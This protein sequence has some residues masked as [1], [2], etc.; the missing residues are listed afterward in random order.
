MPRHIVV[1]AV[2]ALFL[3]GCERSVNPDSA[4]A[5]ASAARVLPYGSW[6]SPISAASLVESARGLGSLRR[7]GDFLYWLES[8]PEEGG[9]T[10]VMRWREGA[11]AEELLPAPW[12]VRTRVQEYG[13]G[14]L[15]VAEGTLFFSNY[16]DQRLYRFR[17]GE[18][19]QPI[20]IE[21]E[22]RFAGCALDAPRSRLICIRE[23]H[24]GLAEPA[25]TL[26]SLRLDADGEQEGEVLFSGADFVSAPSLSA[27]GRRI[28][29]TA[30]MHP[31][32]PWDRTTLYS[33]GFAEDGSLAELTTHNP[34]T[35]ESVLDPRF[36]PDGT[37]YALSDRDNWWRPY[38]VEGERF[39]AVPTGLEA[40]EIGGP[41]WTIGGHYYEPRGDGSL[42]VQARRGSVEE[43]YLLDGRG[44]QRRIETGA[45]GYGSL[46]DDGERLAF[47]AVFPDR[48]A[49]LVRS[50]GGG[51]IL[52]SIRSTR[53]S[54]LAA[55][56]IPA[57][58]QLSFPL[59]GGGEAHGVYYPPAH[60]E[61]AAPAGSAPPLIVTAH[62]GPTSVAGV[63]YDPSLYYWTSRGFAVLDLNYRGSTGFGRSYRRA[64]YGQWGVA[65]V[66]DAVVA[67]EALS[68]KGLADPKRL[69]IRGGSA[70]GYT[71]LAAHAFHDV[72]SAGA[73]YYGISDIEALARDTHK[74]ESRYLDQLIGPYPE[75][76]DLYRA[77]SPIHH[78]EGF[79][80]P[81]ILLQGLDDPVVPPNQ[82]E[83]I[84]K[85]LRERGVATAYRAYKGESH[86]FRKAE[87]QI[88]ARESELYFYSRVLDFSLAEELDAIAIDNIG[89][90]VE[91]GGGQQEADQ[92]QGPGL[93]P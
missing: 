42:L 22:L 73:S 93:Q 92:S 6:P 69:I 27:D 82:S 40:V 13:G 31:N 63:G 88:D 50:D 65:D 86:G 68:E 58:E 3:V 77:R 87:N 48:P 28:A 76:S 14:A 85:A 25:N 15:L 71:T 34:D 72:F 64:L 55:E 45:V 21:G 41:A 39:S 9:R 70:G 35:Q 23:D 56:W 90:E 47:I 84:Y 75:R 7:D 57:F 8:R 5:P 91:T 66:E 79:G 29:F 67:A 83:L 54:A 11:Q 26:V 19:P 51:K 52:D 1:A 61:V 36:A 78:L 74:F 37:L 43:L 46:V 17:P 38:T 60:P 4:A 16:A 49:A 2:A 10:T 89:P 81:L 33:A 44:G 18:E 20:T 80:A 24:R 53:D 30:W 59:P 32:M 62:G 12:N